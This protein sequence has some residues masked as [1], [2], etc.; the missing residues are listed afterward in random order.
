MFR[1]KNL[2]LNLSIRHTF[3][4]QTLIRVNFAK[5]SCYMADG[6]NGSLLKICLLEYEISEV[7]FGMTFYINT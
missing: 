5:L 4:R 1:Q 7:I 2:W 3:P 6:S